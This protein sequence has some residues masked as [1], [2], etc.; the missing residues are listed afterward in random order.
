MHY[1]DDVVTWR[2]VHNEDQ[3]ASRDWD[4]IAKSWFFSHVIST[5][6]DLQDLKGIKKEDIPENLDKFSARFI[7]SAL[8][9]SFKSVKNGNI[10]TIVVVGF[11]TWSQI[12]SWP[13]QFI[14]RV[15]HPGYFSESTLHV[16]S[17][18]DISLAP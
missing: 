18:R 11:K 7:F 14:A 1:C 5:L 16:K 8:P 6:H 12:Y 4:E 3:V 2:I 17:R 15:Q 9:R 13:F 10:N